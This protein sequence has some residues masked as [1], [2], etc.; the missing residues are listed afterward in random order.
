VPLYEHYV[1]KVHRHLSAFHAEVAAHQAREKNHCRRQLSY[2]EL[3]ENTIEHI[4]HHDL[5]A[6]VLHE[7][8][9][10]EGIGAELDGLIQDIEDRHQRIQ[11]LEASLQELKQLFVDL[12]LLVDTQGELVNHI[13]YR[14]QIS[15]DL[16][17]EGGHNLQTAETIQKKSRKRQCCFILLVLGILGALVFIPV[18]TTTFAKA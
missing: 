9:L 2:L 13:E 12:A 14:V 7:A 16:T 18:A 11:T 4:V 3:P 5:T 17:Q 1:H 6:A 8:L 15:V 10:G